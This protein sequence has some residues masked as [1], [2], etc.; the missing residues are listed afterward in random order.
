MKRICSLLMVLAMIFSFAGCT[1]TRESKN[2]QEESMTDADVKQEDLQ[3]KESDDAVE[4]TGPLQVYYV[5]S[6]TGGSID[7]YLKWYGQLQDKQEIEI[8]E[9]VSA[10]E[11][12][13][14]IKG[15]AQPDVIILDKVICTSSISPFGWAKDG[16]L[17]GLSAYLADDISYDEKD[18]INGVMAAGHYK[19]EQYLLPLSLTGQYLFANAAEFETGALTDLNAE[20]TM[21]M[22]METMIQDMQLHEGEEYYSQVPYSFSIVSVADWLYSCLEQTGAL[23]IDH[24]AGTV[25]IDEEMFKLTMEYFRATYRQ[26][27]PF[28]M[29]KTN[30]NTMSLD[31]LDDVSTAI[32]GTYNLINAARYMSSAYHQQLNQDAVMIPFELAEDGYAFGVG[33][34]GMVSANSAQPKAAYQFLR[35]LMDMAHD[36]WEMIAMNNVLA[37]MMPVNI[38]EAQA[39]IES[40][41]TM[42]GGTYKMQ[43]DTF[44]REA[45]TEELAEQL[46]EVLAE[47]RYVYVTDPEVITVLS[48]QLAEYVEGN[49]DDLD[50][51]AE[52]LKSAIEAVL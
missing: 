40:F 42:S 26:V 39:L 43:I 49:T 8:T 25:T 3:E 11:L 21:K 6:S 28:L 32:L 15:D 47:T 34:V 16:Y 18:Y 4:S 13:A 29:G 30:I 5:T 20:Y 37:S 22:V 41:E 2:D 14:A 9:F 52:Q 46:K 24:D 51:V 17:A 7:P 10:E 50:G 1:P 19:G 31:D 36:N 48:Q 12:D 33:L 27:E 45:L 38:N 44:E 23:H 35:T